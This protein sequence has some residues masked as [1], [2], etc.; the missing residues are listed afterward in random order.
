MS[1]CPKR[2]FSVHLR[3][4]D[5][6]SEHSQ[7]VFLAGV[8]IIALTTFRLMVQ[9]M[10]KN[11]EK[12]QQRE[13]AIQ[14]AQEAE[15]KRQQEATVPKTKVSIP[16]TRAPLGDPFGAP[17]AGSARGIAA[18]WE[19]EVH[20]L[21]RQIIGQI[22]CKMAALQAITQDANRTANRLEMLIE[23][24][25][26]I[27]QKQAEWQR[28]TAQT[29][30]E[31]ATEVIAATEPVST[32]APL[33]DLLEELTEDLKGIRGAIRQNTTFSEQPE[34]VTVLRPKSGD[35]VSESTES[36]RGEVEMLLK[37]GLAPQ[38]IARR[39]NISL[40]EVDLVLQVQQNRWERADTNLDIVSP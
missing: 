16:Q 15:R 31:D 39:L 18:K 12:D 35:S 13:R 33:T 20:Q 19:T 37:Y 38:E 25:E 9:R 30:S 40:G 28:Q 2:V 5:W 29:D 6:I 24:L 23:H 11:A 4:M 21:G 26:Q 34:S 27:A 14:V 7:F 32:A 17:F 36:L 22:D 1:S 10:R 8:V 3:A